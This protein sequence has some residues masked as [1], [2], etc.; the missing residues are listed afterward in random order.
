MVSILYSKKP[1]WEVTAEYL[2]YSLPTKEKDETVQSIA[3]FLEGFSYISNASENL[4]VHAK[5]LRIFLPE[6]EE[7]E[8]TFE[9]N[10]MISANFDDTMR[11]MLRGSN[12]LPSPRALRVGDGNGPNENKVT[13]SSLREMVTDSMLVLESRE[14][15][16][17]KPS[18][19]D[20]VRVDVDAPRVLLESKTREK[21]LTWIREMW[22]ASLGDDPSIEK[23]PSMF[24]LEKL[25]ENLVD[26]D[27]DQYSKHRKNIS[28][29]SGFSESSQS[30]AKT[31]NTEL[32]LLELIKPGVVN[33]GGE[34]VVSE[35]KKS[36]PTQVIADECLFVVQISEPQINLRGN[37]RNGRLLLAADN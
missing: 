9:P 6:K 29:T 10:Q 35:M 21:V 2:N 13:A 25:S 26:M 32:D 17:R 5:D 19:K 12:T 16:V 31:A 7:N 1:S 15:R 28:A 24:E 36:P 8:A 23:P 20:E 11:E 3:A 14:F 37:D 27:L 22:Q 18:A 4:N 30:N 34:N 33:N